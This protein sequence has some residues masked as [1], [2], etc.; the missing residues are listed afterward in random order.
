MN[1]EPK[2]QQSVVF[3]DFFRSERVQSPLE[4]VA[5]PRASFAISESKLKSLK[6]GRER[7]RG[8]ATIEY[9]LLLGLAAIISIGFVSTFSTVIRTS[10][11]TFGAVL[12]RELTNGDW[13]GGFQ[14]A[15]NAWEN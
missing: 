14:E 5:C 2:Y 13:A 3:S 8:Q 4:A 1:E 10:M 12:E 7:A 9:A 11:M 6:T 15:G